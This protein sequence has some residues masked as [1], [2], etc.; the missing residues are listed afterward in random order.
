MTPEELPIACSLDADEI[1]QRLAEISAIGGD[2][3]RDVQSSPSQASLRFAAGD[4]RRERLAAI[5]AAEARCCPFMTFELRDEAGAI[6][7]TISAPEGAELVFDDL[8]AAFSGEVP[9]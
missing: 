5:V 4:E 9:A 2:A 3:L 7:M 6:V 1:K 8:V